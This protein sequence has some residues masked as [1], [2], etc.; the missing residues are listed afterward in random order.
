MVVEVDEEEARD[1]CRSGL[2][3]LRLAGTDLPLCPGTVLPLPGDMGPA[4]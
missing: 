2:L 4:H 3:A 1:L